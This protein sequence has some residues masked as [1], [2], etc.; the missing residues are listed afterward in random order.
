MDIKKVLVAVSG[1][2]TDDEAITLGSKLARESKA[3]VYAIYV[4]EVKRALPLDADLPM[5]SKKGEE[6]LNYAEGVA[7][8][9][10]CKLETELLQARQAGPAI[11]DEARERGVDL[12]ILGLDYKTHFGEFTLGKTAPYVLRNASCRVLVCR[13]PSEVQG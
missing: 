2:R 12:I 3:K 9:Q 4:I 7:Q 6:V 1:G 13:E 11:V 8:K 5:E 10:D